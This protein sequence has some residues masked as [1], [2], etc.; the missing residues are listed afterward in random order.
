ME[1]QE[2]YKL[3]ITDVCVE[4]NPDKSK[5]AVITFEGRQGV[6]TARQKIT[7]EEF[8]GLFDCCRR[9]SK[10]IFAKEF[11]LNSAV[12]LDFELTGD[13]GITVWHTQPSTF[14]KMPMNM[15]MQWS[16]VHMQKNYKSFTS[17][18]VVE[19]PNEFKLVNGALPVEE[20][21]QLMLHSMESGIEFMGT[22]VL[23]RDQIDHEKEVR[24]AS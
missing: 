14:L 20:T 9:L 4:T 1:I 16:C 12:D 21:L 15:S 23:Q 6:Q 2:P 18:G 17:L 8:E 13:D 3:K 5:D 19:M 7:S 24:A 10:E 11:R 22:L